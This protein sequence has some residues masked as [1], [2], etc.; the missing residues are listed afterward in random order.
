MYENLDICYQASC[1]EEVMP[2]LEGKL[3]PKPQ[4]GALKFAYYIL[5]REYGIENSNI[6]I[7]IEE[8]SFLG[9]IFQFTPYFK[10]WGSQFLYQ[11]AYFYHCMLM[12]R[13][14][15]GTM[16]FPE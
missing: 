8:K 9:R 7:D 15:K 5:D 14:H 16:R 13:F 3:A 2:L 11:I 10:I 12:P 1:K 4:L 6:D